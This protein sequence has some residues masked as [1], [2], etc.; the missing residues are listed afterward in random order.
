MGSAFS[1]MAEKKAAGF[2]VKEHVTC[3]DRKGVLSET[4][5]ERRGQRKCI[6]MARVIRHHDERRRPWQPFGVDDLQSMIELE[7][8]P[9]RH[10]RRGL[11]EKGEETRF[12]LKALQLFVGGKM[13]IPRRLIFPIVHGVTIR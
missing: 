8:T 13:L 6:E 3:G 12:A 11:R 1:A 5:G 9:D 4:P 2:R 10:S 7:I